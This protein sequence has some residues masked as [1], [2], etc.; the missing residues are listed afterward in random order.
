MPQEESQKFITMMDS[1][2]GDVE[3]ETESTKCTWLGLRRAPAAKRNHHAYEG[4]LVRHLIEMYEFWTVLRR[5][6]GQIEVDGVCDDARVLKAILLH[7][8]EKAD[9]NFFL[10]SQDPWL[11]DYN[12]KSDRQLIL[13]GDIRSVEIA[14]RFGITLDAVQLNALMW[15]HGGFSELQ[16]KAHSALA[17]LVYLLDEFSGNV[18]ERVRMGDALGLLPAGKGR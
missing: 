15:A 4:G 5:E 16:P 3:E 13:P 9:Q 17:K 10:V 18:L 1:L 2:S 6:Y 7:D 11:V 8:I 14:F 12:Y